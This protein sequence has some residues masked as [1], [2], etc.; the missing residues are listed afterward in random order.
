MRIAWNI[1][2]LLKF[3][4]FSNTVIWWTNLTSN[5]C[6]LITSLPYFLLIQFQHLI[7]AEREKE[8]K[9]ELTLGEIRRIY[10]ATAPFRGKWRNNWLYDVIMITWRHNHIMWQLKYWSIFFV[11]A[12]VSVSNSIPRRSH[13]K[14]VK[15]RLTVGIQWT[16]KQLFK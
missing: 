10:A 13:V 9:P 11:I 3:S 4:V 6:I 8:V 1:F 14:D 12:E 16:P 15:K 5:V 2:S 7:E